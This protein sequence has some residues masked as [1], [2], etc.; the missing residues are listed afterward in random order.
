LD[1]R[2]GEVRI[3]SGNAPGGS[4]FIAPSFPTN[5]FPLGS[6]L[7]MRVR[8][9]A[10]IHASH[11]QSAV[12]TTTTSLAA[13]VNTN[14]LVGGTTN[15]TSSSNGFNTLEVGRGT[16]N[17]ETV[18]PANWSIVDSTHI[19][20]TCANVHT[21]G[22]ANNN[23]QTAIDL[24]QLGVTF[25]DKQISFVFNPV[26]PASRPTNLPIPLIDSNGG[27]FLLFP[28]NIASDPFPLN[29]IQFET[30]ITGATAGDTDQP[31][32]L[33]FRNSSAFN[34]IRFFDF[35][36]TDHFDLNGDGTISS[37]AVWRLT[38][39]NTFTG[40]SDNGIT[41][42]Y[43]FNGNTGA[44]LFSG[45]IQSTLPTGLPPIVVASTTPVANLTLTNHPTVQTCGGTSTCSHT[46]VGTSQ[47]IWGVAPLVSGSPSTVTI[48]GFSPA[49]TSTTSFIC[50]TG[51][52]AAISLGVANTSPSSITI[53]GPN[54]VTN[55]VNFICVGN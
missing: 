15:L 47:I 28:V 42:T 18:S 48:S 53:T 2:G 55:T 44:A 43:Q 46:Q 19:N 21:V 20:I 40:Y 23:N 54:T 30:P 26:K 37:N 10:D 13:G 38:F 34:A 5:Q 52:S 27:T 14:V 32:D 41:R 45:E 6:D 3:L 50:T 8:G 1:L 16:P 7:T 31:A 25:F 39:G 29:A 17:E 36:G 12:T 51:S 4:A 11:I 33:V 9:P 49:Y 24:E 22:G 35:G